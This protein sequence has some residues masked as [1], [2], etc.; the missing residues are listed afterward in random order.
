MPID[1]LKGINPV[2]SIDLSGKKLGVASAVIIGTCIAGNALLRELKCALPFKL[3]N[4]CY[5]GVWH[6][7][8]CHVQYSYS[9]V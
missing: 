2:E 1:E 7:L 4:S 5:T 6:K 9:V 3:E 8:V